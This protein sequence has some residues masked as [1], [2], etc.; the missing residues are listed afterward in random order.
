MMDTCW[1]VL[2]GV[3]TFREMAPY[4]CPY[5]QLLS[6]SSHWLER[7]QILLTVSLLSLLLVVDQAYCE[8]HYSAVVGQAFSS[9]SSKLY[10]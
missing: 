9:S 8:A 4:S 5:I 1:I 6:Q 7:V 2:R 3:R 10:L